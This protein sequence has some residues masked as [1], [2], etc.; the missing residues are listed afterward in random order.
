[1]LNDYTPSHYRFAI[2]LSHFLL[3]ARR[4]GQFLL[5]RRGYGSIFKGPAGAQ[6]MY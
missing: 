4:R 3:Q 2:V 1:M 6:P 5:S